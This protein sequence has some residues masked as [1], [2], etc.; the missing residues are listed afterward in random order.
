MWATA[1][2]SREDIV[3]FYQRACA[4][5]DATIAALPLDALGTVHWWRAGRVTLHRLL[6]HVTAETHRHAGHAD[7]V[8][9][10]IDGAVGFRSDHDNLPELDAD[11]WTAYHAR[12]EAAAREAA[13]GT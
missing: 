10:L 1:E 4:H 12:L 9:E 2:E 8:R 11:A 5:A 6:V 3:G 13:D 7:L